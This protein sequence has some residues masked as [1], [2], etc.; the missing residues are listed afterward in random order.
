MHR[1]TLHRI[2]IVD[3]NQDVADLLAEIFS[4]HGHET[5]AVYCGTDGILAALDFAPDVVFLDINMPGM[6]GFDVVA[7][8][9]SITAL[10]ASLIAFTSLDDP[11]TAKQIL[12]AG[13]D[14]HLVKTAEFDALL[15]ALETRPG[16][17][18]SAG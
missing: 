14:L 11:I 17:R 12:Q 7:E 5:L 13:F 9:L 2:L 15:S 8:L 10:R 18:A 4:M 16:A 1:S 6:N 3:D